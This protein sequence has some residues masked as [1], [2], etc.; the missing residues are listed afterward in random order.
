MNKTGTPALERAAPEATIHIEII[1]MD[2]EMH[3]SFCKSTLYCCIYV[4]VTLYM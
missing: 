3:F 4:F 1:R 2:A